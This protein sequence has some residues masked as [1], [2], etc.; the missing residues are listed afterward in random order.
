MS[1][2][3]MIPEH[4]YC[5]ATRTACLPDKPCRLL[6]QHNTD[7]ARRPDHTGGRPRL[8]HRLGSSTSPGISGQGRD[9]RQVRKV[10]S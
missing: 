4:K 8:G 9:G 5:L 3:Y 1:G 7:C 6:V 10:S 2:L